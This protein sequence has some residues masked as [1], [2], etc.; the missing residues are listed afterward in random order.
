MPIYEYYCPPCHTIFSFLARGLNSARE[1]VCPRCGRQPLEKQVSRFAISKGLREPSAAKDPLDNVD[2]AKMESLMAEMA[3]S[4]GEDGEGGGENP[5]EMARM[6]QKLFQV[7]GMQPSDAMSEAIR[8]MEAGEDPDK[9][10]EEMGAL[11]DAE[12]PFLAGEGGMQ[13]RLRRFIEPPNIDPE[14]YDL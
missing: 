12:E 14:L 8:R 7:T 2:E 9:I 1:P 4:F 3:S 13:G 10:D 5:H 6:M 11:L